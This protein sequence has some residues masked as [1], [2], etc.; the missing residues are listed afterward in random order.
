MISNVAI[1]KLQANTSVWQSSQR[2]TSDSTVCVTK[3]VLVPTSLEQRCFHCLRSKHLPYWSRACPSLQI[4]YIFNSQASPLCVERY[5]KA[6]W[7]CPSLACIKETW[8][9]CLKPHPFVQAWVM[10]NCLLS[11]VFLWLNLRRER[12]STEWETDRMC[13]LTTSRLKHEQLF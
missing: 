6:Q 8:I 9:R 12:F 3:W 5:P 1:H 7:H 10:V 13:N 11:L 2:Y 4:S